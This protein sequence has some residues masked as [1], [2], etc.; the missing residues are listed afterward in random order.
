VKEILA[1]SGYTTVNTL[2]SGFSGPQGVAVDGSGKRLRADFADAPS[3]NFASTAVGSTSS[4]SPI[5]EAL[6]FLR[7]VRTTK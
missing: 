7:V 2:G 6:A 5:E 4:D 1:A 3:L